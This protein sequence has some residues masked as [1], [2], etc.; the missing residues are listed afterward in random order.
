VL[1]GWG[2]AFRGGNAARKFEAIDAYVRKRL[3]IYQNRRRGRNDPTW[4][5]EFDYAWY[6]ELNL[7]RLIGIIRYPG[8]A[9]AG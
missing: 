7:V 4:A 8:A 2:E 1:R 6:R 5:R 9:N 3:V